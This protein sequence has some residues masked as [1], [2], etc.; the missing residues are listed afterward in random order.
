MTFNKFVI[1]IILKVF[2]FS[3]AIA[4]NNWEDMVNKAGIL[5]DKEKY[6]EALLTYSE[7]LQ[8]NSEFEAIKLSRIYNNIGFCHFKLKDVDNAIY[9]YKKALELDS[10]YS[11]CFNNLGA[12]FMGQKKYE[13]ALFL[14]KKSYYIEKTNIKV[15]FNLF[16]INYYLK[17]KK[18]AIFFIDEAFKIDENYTESRLRK[19]NISKS[20][21][22]KLRK[23]LENYN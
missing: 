4:L 7:I 17:N 10:N 22:K 12:V 1:F 21:I 2:V 18:E 3:F 11:T 15:L 9:Y 8:K 6:D 14:L 19:K 20:D 16:V 5:I 13:E 23:Y